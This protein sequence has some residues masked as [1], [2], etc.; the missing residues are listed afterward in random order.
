MPEV[1]TTRARERGQSGQCLV[2]EPDGVHVGE[3][4]VVHVA[5]DD[6]QVD[7]LRGDHVEQVVDVRRLVL[8]HADTMERASQVPVGGVEYPHRS[9]LGSTTD[10]T[11]EARLR[12]SGRSA[13]GG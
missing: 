11:A 10:R 1:S 9:N 6:H 12:R 8:E 7:A 4:A 13:P 3:C 5:R 2:G